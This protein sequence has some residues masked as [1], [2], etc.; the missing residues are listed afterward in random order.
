MWLPPCVITTVFC[1]SVIPKLRVS[2]GSCF[3]GY[4]GKLTSRDMIPTQGPYHGAEP[5]LLRKDSLSGPLAKDE[6]AL[7]IADI[8]VVSPLGGHPRPQ[9]LPPP[10]RLVAHLPILESWNHQTRGWW[11]ALHRSVRDLRKG[12][13]AS[14]VPTQ[15]R[16]HAL[17]LALEGLA[18]E[19]SAPSHGDVSEE[20]PPEGRGLTNRAKAW[21]TRH[22]IDPV[23]DTPPV[24]VDWIWVTVEEPDP[25]ELPGIDFPPLEGIPDLDGPAAAGPAEPPRSDTSRDPSAGQEGAGQD[26]AGAHALSGSAQLSAEPAAD[27]AA[28][29]SP[30]PRRG[31]P[32]PR[33]P[34][35][36]RQ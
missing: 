32:A 5:G 14:G 24:A 17:T 15:K 35:T 19:E 23:S 26:G 30:R 29:K 31:P 16:V 18:R 11:M 7:V 6:Q 20:K 28:R 12:T 3:I 13:S 34:R 1:N 2:G 25:K 36:P 9:A 8:D 27:S 4:V 22:L 33:R 10:L 21:K